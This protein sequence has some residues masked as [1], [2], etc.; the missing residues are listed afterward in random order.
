MTIC[1]AKATKNQININE[2]FSKGKLYIQTYKL[3]SQK[4][5]VLDKDNVLKIEVYKCVIIN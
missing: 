2:E 5:K 4:D 3:L 1:R